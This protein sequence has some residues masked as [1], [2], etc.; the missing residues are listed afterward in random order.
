MSEMKNS[1]DG[2]SGRLDTTEVKISEFDGNLIEIN[3]HSET[4]KGKNRGEKH[5]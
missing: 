4:Q 1:L 3:N 2:I 5:R